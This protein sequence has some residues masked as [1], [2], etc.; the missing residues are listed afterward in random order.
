[1]LYLLLCRLNLEFFKARDVMRHPVNTITPRE[2]VAHLANL[3]V[4]TTHGGFPVVKW[5]EET[6]QEVAY[7]LLTRY[8]TSS[9]GYPRGLVSLSQK[10][11]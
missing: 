6:R 8:G 3:L 1:M 9:V 7:G 4:E 10:P 2:N 11:H 5:H